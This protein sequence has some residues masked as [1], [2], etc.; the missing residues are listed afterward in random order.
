[1]PVVF[2]ISAAV[3]SFSF[4]FLKLTRNTLAYMPIALHSL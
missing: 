3:R 2:E 1:M 4:F